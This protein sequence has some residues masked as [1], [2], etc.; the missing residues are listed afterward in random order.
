MIAWTVWR[1]PRSLRHLWVALPL[2]LL[3]ALP[4][5]VWNAG[6]GWE[7]L[8]SPVADT[9]TY[10][11]RLRLLP[12]PVLPMTLGLRAPLTSRSA[13]SPGSAHLPHLRGAARPRS[14]S[15]RSARARRNASLLYSSS[16]SSRSLYALPRKTL[17][18]GPTPVH[19]RSSR[20]C[21]RS[22][23]RRSRRRSWRAAAVSSPSAWSPRCRSIRMEAWLTIRPAAA[24]GAAQPQ[25]ADLDARPARASTAS[26]PTTGSPTVL[27]FDTRERIIAVENQF[28]ERDASPTARRPRPTT[29]RC[30]TPPT[31]REVRAARHGFVFWRQT[32]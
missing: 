20:R 15:A 9:T 28:S 12:S 23:S 24:D 10:A 29:R 6:H 16:P 2:A 19:R 25:P 32:V 31:R 18:I 21:S 1:Q 5:L 22:C 3:G 8:N 17:Y 11:H 26:T 7:S 27:D 4:W 30:A 13:A 14:S